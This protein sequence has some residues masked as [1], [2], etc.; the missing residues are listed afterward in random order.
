MCY[1]CLYGLAIW[2]RVTCEDVK[3]AHCRLVQQSFI[4]RSSRLMYF[5][6]IQALLSMK[7]LKCKP[8]VLWS[9]VVRALGFEKVHALMRKYTEDCNAKD[10]GC[11][12]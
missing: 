7:A 2:H 4:Q 8:S 9:A 3:S 12:R 11:S 10:G 1:I 6:G 5:C